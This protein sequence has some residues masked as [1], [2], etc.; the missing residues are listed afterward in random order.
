MAGGRPRGRP[1]NINKHDLLPPINKYKY[2]NPAAAALTNLNLPPSALNFYP[3]HPLLMSAASFGGKVD[4][5]TAALSVM[6]QNYQE[7]MRQYQSNLALQSFPNALTQEIA[8]SLLANYPSAGNPSTS[9]SIGNCSNIKSSNK[10]YSS[11]SNKDLGSR[12]SSS[13]SKDSY[14]K[15]LTKELMKSKS[16]PNKDSILKAVYGK[17]KSNKNKETSKQQDLYKKDI[18]LFKDRPYISITQIS[19]P[20]PPPAAVNLIPPKLPTTSNSGKTLQQK[21]AERQKQN[22]PNKNTSSSTSSVSINYPTMPIP[23]PFPSSSPPTAHSSQTSRNNN[24][25]VNPYGA[26]I[27]AHSNTVTT[28]LKSTTT[29]T[30]IL[31][32]LPQTSLLKKS[33]S[34]DTNPYIPSTSPIQIS[35]PHQRPSSK[36]NT[37]SLSITQIPKVPPPSSS[38]SII[39]STTLPTTGTAPSNKSQTSKLLNYRKPNLSKN[40]SSSSTNKSSSTSGVEYVSTLPPPPPMTKK[41]PPIPSPKNTDPE[42]IILDDD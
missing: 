3:F 21:L 19:P 31:P 36:P 24:V 8:Q 12:S 1:P 18:N 7:L 30:S 15:L 33:K 29:A 20:P 16:A 4:P 41:P 27:A 42:I 11:F 25:F 37:E 2:A 28:S 35:P 13:S 39:S 5:S 6:M 17:E 10:K 9:T 40:N 34:I 23:N 22:S 14:S 26:P 38:S 32:P